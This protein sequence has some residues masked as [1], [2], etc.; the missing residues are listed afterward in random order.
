MF[1]CN[2]S[3]YLNIITDIRLFIGRILNRFSK[4]MGQIDEQLP[5]ALGE[6]VFVSNATLCISLWHVFIH[7]SGS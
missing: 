1:Q 6:I 5:L 7:S 4:D 2:D 3:I